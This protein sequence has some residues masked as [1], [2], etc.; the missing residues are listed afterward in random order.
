MSTDQ[1]IP[2]IAI[3]LSLLS[4]FVSVYRIYRDRSKLFAFCEV[5]YDNTKNP[6]NPPPVLKIYAVN[7]GVRPITLTDFGFQVS[8]KSVTWTPLKPEPIETDEEGYFLSFPQNLFHNIGIKMEDGD[9]Y[10][11]RGGH[12]D[13]DSLYSSNHDFKEAE[14]YFFKDI[15][16]NR[17]YV[18]GSKK[19]IH[20]ILKH[21]A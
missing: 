19:G 16:G 14:K 12:E 2:W 15:L 21:K 1:I 20:R 6:E 18:K 3:C 5:V 11:V 10:E 17:Y 13:Y 8:K 7:R 4:L 9:I